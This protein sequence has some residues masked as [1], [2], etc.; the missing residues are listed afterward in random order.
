MNYR[1]RF[2]MGVFTSLSFLMACSHVQ[3]VDEPLTHPPKI[4][5]KQPCLEQETPPEFTEYTGHEDIKL[6][7]DMHEDIPGNQDIPEEEPPEKAYE[8]TVP[9]NPK[10]EH[11]IERYCYK[12]RRSFEKSLYRVDQIRPTMER[13]FEEASLP[14]DLVYMSLVESGGNFDAIS[15]SG[16]MGY[17]QFMPGT[18]KRYGL[19][20][21]RWVDERRDLE[22]ST[23]AA[24]RYLSHL[25]SIFGD[26]LLACAAYN[27]GEGTIKRLMK[28]YPDITS[29][30]DISRHMSIKRETLAYVPKFLATLTIGKNRQTYGLKDNKG[31][32]APS[33]DVVVISSFA[34]LEEIS[35]VIGEPVSKLTRLNAELIRGCTPPLSKEYIIKVPKGTKETISNCLSQRQNQH[36]EYTMHSTKRG[37]TLYDIAKRYNSNVYKIAK[38][39]RIKVSNILPIGKVLVVP[40]NISKVRKDKHTYVVAKGDTLKKISGAYGVTLEDMIEI[41]NITN[42]ELIFPETVLRLPPP[43]PKWVKAKGRVV[44]YQ[45]RKGDTIWDISRLYDVSTKS[46]IRWNQLPSTAQ[47]YPGD[48]LTIYVS[49]S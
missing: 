8:I 32:Q 48:K 4:D 19:R 39:N 18:A 5:Q 13:I 12:E 23:L 43:H 16:A 28:K 9:M 44:L 38:A 21:D 10:V 36:I 7:K 15:R 24:T 1:L 30:W 29:F 2:L 3:I 42:P 26:W 17:W 14:K 6:E 31:L 37:D 41:N 11:W 27:A 49:K 25:Y 34:Y 33:Y 20:V 35:D 22:K 40:A 47:I 46:I 45:V